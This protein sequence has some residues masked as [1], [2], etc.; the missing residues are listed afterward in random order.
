[1]DSIHLW[2]PINTERGNDILGSVGTGLFGTEKQLESGIR[3]SKPEERKWGSES[4]VFE[5]EKK[6]LY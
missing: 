1:M 4:E 3:G 5:I 6:I 2:T